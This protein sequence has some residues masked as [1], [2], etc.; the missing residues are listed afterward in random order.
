MLRT[1]AQVLRHAAAGA[2]TLAGAA[3]LIADGVAAQSSR[4]GPPS[5]AAQQAANGQAEA[6]TSTSARPGNTGWSLRQNGAKDPIA[7]HLLEDTAMADV[8]LPAGVD[9]AAVVCIAGCGPERNIV[10]YRPRT[11]SPALAGVQGP[12]ADRH[13]GAAVLIRASFNSVDSGAAGETFGVICVAGCYTDIARVIPAVSVAD[14][15]P[16]RATPTKRAERAATGRANGRGQRH[17]RAER[18]KRQTAKAA[19]SKP[20]KA[21][22]H[23][24][25]PTMSTKNVKRVAGLRTRTHR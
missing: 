19:V 2:M 4:S 3:L 12:A 1:A 9:P 5:E 20:A 13:S 22:K 23:Q 14:A 16:Q 6:P 21:A 18:A 11:I 25:A 7:D 24:A 10:V 15:R 8:K 17:V